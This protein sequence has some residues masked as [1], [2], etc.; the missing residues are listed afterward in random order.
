MGQYVFEKGR[1]R[2]VR[3]SHLMAAKEFYER[4]GGKAIVLARFVPL[5]RT[6]TPFV[7]GVARM[8]Y[9]KFVIYN[10]IGGTSWVLS[11]TWAGYWLGQIP[12]IQRNFEWMVIIIVLISVLPLAITA[13]RH[14]LSP[15]RP[16]LV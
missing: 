12:W 6:F 13:L 3:H 8:G 15:A 16:S 10:I 11:M 4:H 7:A 9:R 2:F 1:L 5:V 14:W